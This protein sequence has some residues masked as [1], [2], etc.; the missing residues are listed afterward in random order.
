LKTFRVVRIYRAFLIDSA[1]LERRLRSGVRNGAFSAWVLHRWQ[2]YK[3]IS[4]DPWASE[5]DHDYIDIANVSQARHDNL[6]T[7][8]R[9]RLTPFGSRS[10]IWRRTS[11]EA[12][13]QLPDSELDFVYLDARHDEASVWEDLSLWYPK[14]APGGIIAGH[15]YLDGDLPEGHFAVK[16][17]VDRFFADRD[18]QVHTTTDDAPWLTWF[19]LAR[20]S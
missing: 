5:S 20:H 2:G 6:L 19:V 4:V 11:R 14:L 18:R 17:A 15:D 7:Q 8:A 12:A 10:E 3:L 9:Y 16:T 1:C 13:E